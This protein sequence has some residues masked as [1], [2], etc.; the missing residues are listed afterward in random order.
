MLTDLLSAAPGTIIAQFSPLPSAPE[1]LV[2][3]AQASG[4]S[5]PLHLDLEFA[6]QAGFDNL[7][8]HGMLNMA[9][10][11]RLLTEHFPAERIRSF[12]ARFEGVVLVGQR[13]TYRASL[14][15]R[16]GDGFQLALEGLLLNGA[17]VISGQAFVSAS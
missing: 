13:V 1:D 9:H 16:T 4:D 15:E 5:N 2:R 3:Y 11:G 17:R 12:S 8:V 14:A 6:R 7:V 10:L